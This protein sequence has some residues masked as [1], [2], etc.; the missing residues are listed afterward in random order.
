[1]DNL[2]FD[3]TNR[4]SAIQLFRYGLVGITS[5]L[6][7]Y[8]VYLLITYLGGT[9]KITMSL[10]YGVGASI[11]FWGNR[12]LTFAHKGSALEASVR[13]IIVHCFGYFINLAI[14][15]VMVDK[16]GYAHQWVQA[17]AVFVVAVFLFLA[18]KF[19]VFRRP[20]SINIGN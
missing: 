14:L 15:I 18:F 7:G 20:Y 9:P 10:L 16:L 5:N 4:K 6:T 11:G 1:M 17:I 13:Y 8:M 2:L 12:K 19:F 3:I